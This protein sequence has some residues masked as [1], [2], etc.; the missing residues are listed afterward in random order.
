MAL[1][2]V[3]IVSPGGTVG[4]EEATGEAVVMEV[5]GDIIT[6]DLLAMAPATGGTEHW[7]KRVYITLIIMEIHIMQELLMLLLNEQDIPIFS[8]LAQTMLSTCIDI[9]IIGF[10]IYACNFANLHNT[11]D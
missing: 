2:G 5:E 9:I 4:E 6:G 7:R 3:T 8:H 10:K 11:A 1:V